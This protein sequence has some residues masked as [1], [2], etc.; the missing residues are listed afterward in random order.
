MSCCQNEKKDMHEN[1]KEYYGKTLKGTKDLKTNSCLCSE[2]PPKY[3]RDAISLL[4][5]DIVSHY[6]GCGLVIPDELEGLTCLDLGCGAGHD[7]YIL[8]KL[9]GENGKVFGVDMTK[10]QLEIAEKY[11]DYQAKICG[12]SKSN[13]KFINGY[14]ENLTEIPDNS[15]DI[16]VSNCVVNLSPNKKAVF[17]EA[18]RVL[19]PGGEMYFSDVYSDR[20]IPE[21]LLHDPVLHGECLSGALYWNDFLSLVKEVGFKSPRLVKDRI[22][23]IQNEQIEKKIGFAN[24]FS[25]TYRLFKIPDFDNSDGENYGLKVS[26][27]GTISTC[28]DTFV[29]DN[30]NKFEKGKEYSVCGNTFRI[31]NESRFNKHF[32]FSGNFDTHY[33]IMT[34]CDIKIPFLSFYKSDSCCS[35]DKKNEIEQD[36]DYEENENDNYYYYPNYYF[37]QYNPWNYGNYY[38]YNK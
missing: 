16:I 1:A 5:K 32:N 22:I 20:K 13:V 38:Y 12:Y 31:L 30:K 18:Y 33:G 10:Q 35:E 34:N 4:H 29:L 24:F 36:F 19:K 14:I 37:Y 23:T 9:V 15:I 25:G 21:K 27:K 17:S 28:P 7:V 2:K 6:Y 11:K 26:Y 8:S 3:I